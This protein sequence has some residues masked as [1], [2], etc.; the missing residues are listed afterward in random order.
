[1]LT[2]CQRLESQLVIVQYSLVVIG[3]LT[4]VLHLLRELGPV[5]GFSSYLPSVLDAWLDG[6]AYLRF[7]GYLMVVY[8]PVLAITATT[9]RIKH[10][11]WPT[12]SEVAL[13]L[14][15]GNTLSF[16]C[17]FAIQRLTLH[18]FVYDAAE[19]DAFSFFVGLAKLEF[20]VAFHVMILAVL[21]LMQLASRHR[22]NAD[23]SNSP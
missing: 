17:D 18:V 15:T 16:S 9:I 2:R 6:R 12:L 19:R 20:A 8:F 21:L 22:A 10:Q 5:T 23:C 13:A 3:V 7:I 1:M 14:F 11:R 4:I